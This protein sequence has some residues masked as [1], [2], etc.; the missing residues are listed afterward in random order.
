MAMKREVKVGLFVFAGMI[1]TAAVVFFIGDE[2]RL[3]ES[4]YVF[5]ATFGDVQGLKPGAPVR[6]SGVDIG[7]VQAVG[8]GGDANDNRLYVSFEVVRAEAA[9]IRTDSVAKVGNKGLLGD[10]MLEVS[11]GTPGH[12]AQMPACSASAAGPPASAYSS[13]AG[14]STGVDGAPLTRRVTP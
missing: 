13:S 4:K 11:P 6:L 9:R 2:R 14:C 8:H 1:V 10:K 5:K 7:Y 12:A 3:F